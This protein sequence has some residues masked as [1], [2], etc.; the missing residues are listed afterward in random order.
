MIEDLE[1]KPLVILTEKDDLPPVPSL[2]DMMRIASYDN[3][4]NSSHYTICDG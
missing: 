3:S 4:S 1:I 2:Y